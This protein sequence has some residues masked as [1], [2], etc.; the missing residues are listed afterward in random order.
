M[1]KKV[2]KGTGGNADALNRNLGQQARHVPAEV[3]EGGTKRRT[4]EGYADDYRA[5]SEELVE[6]SR[7]QQEALAQVKTLESQLNAKESDLKKLKAQRLRDLDRL[8]AVSRT[9]DLLE[10]RASAQMAKVAAALA[11]PV[12][13]EPV[14]QPA[15]APPPPPPPAPAPVPALPP[16]APAQIAPAARQPMGFVT[17]PP[18]SDDKRLGWRDDRWWR[19]TIKAA[20]DAHKERR[21]ADAELLLE[22]AL[23]T[24]PTSGL[25]EQLGHVLRESG[26]YLEAEMAYRHALRLRPDHAEM[27][28]LSGYCLEMAGQP[29]EAVRLYEAAVAS[30]PKL[31]NRYEHLIDF[32][33]RLAH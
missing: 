8:A 4:W 29:G 28:F 10:K 33:A 13:A 17:R 19:R 3:P 24:K 2:K 20:N 5:L 11:R 25:W 16:E 18:E 31:V 9:R 27:L 6:M 12:V 15:I 22:V 32:R 30:D 26:Q 7:R 14:A 21:L 1:E 23:L